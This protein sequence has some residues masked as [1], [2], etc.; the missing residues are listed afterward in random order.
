M[1]MQGY[2]DEAWRSELEPL[3]CHADSPGLRTFVGLHST[4]S[5]GL[6]MITSVP[7]Q[8]IDLGIDVGKVEV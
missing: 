8:E 7:P 2:I 6:G 4:S 5:S 1:Y 3:T